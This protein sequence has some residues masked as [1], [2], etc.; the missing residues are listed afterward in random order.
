MDPSVVKVSRKKHLSTQPEFSPISRRDGQT[1]DGKQYVHQTMGYYLTHRLEQF[2]VFCILL[3]FISIQEI[4]AGNIF[5]P[6]SAY[7]VLDLCPFTVRGCCF[8]RVTSSPSHTG[9]F[10]V[11]YW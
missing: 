7:R 3:L 5:Q 4:L 11:H 8:P 1:V 6:I 10:L 2:R 9:L